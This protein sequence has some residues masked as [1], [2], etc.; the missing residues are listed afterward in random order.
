M[1]ASDSSFT[2]TGN[3]DAI[4]SVSSGNVQLSVALSKVN[5]PGGFYLQ[6]D[7]RQVLF[8]A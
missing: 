8:A 4:S 7:T 6:A 1:V 2:G 5:K 3:G